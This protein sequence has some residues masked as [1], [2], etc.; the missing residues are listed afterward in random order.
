[1]TLLPNEVWLKILQDVP[2]SER[3]RIRMVSRQVYDC[4][5]LLK[6][7]GR[8]AIGRRFYGTLEAKF[9]RTNVPTNT[10]LEIVYCKNDWVGVVDEIG[11]KIRRKVFRRDGKTYI[12]H[13]M[14]GVSNNGYGFQ[15]RV[16]FYLDN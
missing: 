2:A 3:K 6:P 1:M 13:C 12:I 8:L 15:R 16:K 5:L 10:Y 11:K 14:Y 9:N 7:S 4:G